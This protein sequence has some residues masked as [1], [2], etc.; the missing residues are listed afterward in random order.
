MIIGQGGSMHP[1]WGRVYKKR[2]GCDSLSLN[3]FLYYGE[4]VSYPVINGIAD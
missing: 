2:K 4:Q 1:E 3:I